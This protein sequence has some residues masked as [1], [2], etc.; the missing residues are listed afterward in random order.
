ML[1]PRRNEAR[2]LARVKLESDGTSRDWLGGS[3]R[4]LVPGLPNSQGQRDGAAQ[5]G[6]FPQLGGC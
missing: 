6:V 4:G 2:G 1:A 5:A 3:G